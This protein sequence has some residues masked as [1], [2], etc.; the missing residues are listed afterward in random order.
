M[1][2]RKIMEEKISLNGTTSFAVDITHLPKGT[3]QLWVKGKTINEER[4][5]VKE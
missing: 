2:G 4:K 5:F 3:Y 1:T